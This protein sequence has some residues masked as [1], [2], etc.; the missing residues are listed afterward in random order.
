MKH[1]FPYILL[2]LSGLAFT[3]TAIAQVRV[4]AKVEIQG[5]LYPGGHFA[6]GIIIENAARPTQID[7]APLSPFNPQGPSHN[8]SISM[9]NFQ[10][11]K[12]TN[13]V[14]YVLTAPQPGSYR[15]E[16]L[17]V[18]VDGIQYTTNPVEFSVAKPGTTDKLELTCTLSEK[19]CF[20]GQP[21]VLSVS[22]TSLTAVQNRDMT[23]PIFQSKE[24]Y[25]EDLVVP[26]Q[27]KGSTNTLHGVSFDVYSQ[28]KMIRGMEATIL[29]FSKVLIPKN[30]GRFHFDPVT[31]SA[32]VHIGFT[33]SNDFFQSIRRKFQRFQIQSEP[34]SLEVKPLPEEGKP[35]E[36]YGLIGSYT[37][38]T[39]AR[40][41]DVSV[42]DPITLE[43]HIG[44]NP[45][46]TPVQWPALEDIVALTDDFRLPAEKASPKRE[47]DS[48][49]FTQ[50]LRAKN[51]GVTEIPPIP[52]VTFDPKTATYQTVS[53]DPIPLTV[54]ASQVL[55]SDDLVGFSSQPKNR[56]V[57]AIKEGLA[58]N[59]EGD[60]AL[61]NQQHSIAALVVSPGPL[62]LWALPL[63]GL[64][65]SLA[66]KA[67]KH[68]TPAQVAAKRRRSAA[69]QA[70]KTLGSVK[71]LPSDQRPEKLS[72]ALRQFIGDRFDKTAGSLTAQECYHIVVER[73]GSKE[74]AQGLQAILATCEAAR[75]APAGVDI[76][77][78][79]LDQAA[80]LVK[81]IDR[82]EKKA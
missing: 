10:S 11:R 43:I 17:S 2:L 27:G 48:L 71:T 34:L 14:S 12:V 67:A 73:T 80:Q 36:F 19:S 41:T 32:D 76:D 5:E 79:A 50:T 46:L 39:E 9:R 62:A 81:T 33:K 54:A 75:Y 1:Q 8:Q 38:S 53:S 68:T 7:T 66:Y 77:E 74:S 69:G 22:W 26:G 64:V 70:L 59:F 60:E 51:D 82:G 63:L 31:A 35:Q 52:L 57:E 23:I 49:V 61:R 15:I 78:P 55:D 30:P 56:A 58:A 21:V 28:T 45:Y 24:F 42:G 13:T 65:S 20:V 72:Q 3:Q 18:T 6:Y 47:Q 29:S 44:G 4:Y 16:G 25:F 40:P 37:I